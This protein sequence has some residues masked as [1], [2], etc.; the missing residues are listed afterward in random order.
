MPAAPIRPLAIALMELRG[1]ASVP[2]AL[3][4]YAPRAIAPARLLLLLALLRLQ[5]LLALLR[6]HVL[7]L[8]ALL[9]TQLLALLAVK[10]LLA[11]LLPLL[12]LQLT[13]FP[14]LLHPRLPVNA[15]LLGGR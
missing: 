6:A 7:Q 5:A 4:V 12:G 13:Q 11:K 15:A 8:L 10:A 9:R 3:R 1:E 14:A 2:R